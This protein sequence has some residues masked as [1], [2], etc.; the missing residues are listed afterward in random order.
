MKLFSI[1]LLASY[2][3]VDAFTADYG[4]SNRGSTQRTM[5]LK[6]ELN[7]PE[8]MKASAAM[9][10]NM[11]P[12]DIDMMLNQIENMPASETEQMRKMGMNP[13]V[14]KQ[15][16]R[17][18]KSNPEMAKQMSKM[19]ETMTPEEMMEKSREAQ[20][21]FSTMTPPPQQPE[22]IDVDVEE[23]NSD[24]PPPDAKVLDAMFEVGQL[25][26]NPQ[27]DGVTLQGFKS[28]PAINLLLEDNSN[29]ITTRRLNECWAI[30]S[31]GMSRV[32]RQ[33]FERVWL[34]V[35]KYVKGDI[36]SKA[37]ELG[38]SSSPAN[39]DVAQPATPGPQ[40]GASV[41]TEELEDRVKKM[42]DKDMDNMLDQMTNM[43]PEQEVRMKAMG[44]NPEMMRRTASMMQNNPLMKNAAK[45]M[46]K[47][48]S[49]DQ[50]K[51][52]SVQAQER[53]KNMSQEDMENMLKQMN[54][55]S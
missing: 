15:S 55:K 50:M 19:M 30:G 2:P 54:Q 22:V 43:T 17:M 49:G 41:S 35:Q 53:L 12:E 10:K 24:L 13:E 25:M 34:S 9:M 16:L 40:V 27:G 14:M 28:L 5:S 4:H 44:V 18:M 6:D 48:I 23:D 47:N 42:S 8:Y 36:M 33:G 29:K 26:S 21:R 1:L 45:S 52:A 11:K 3:A 37:R 32:D 46:M 38:S 51:A 20:E 31:L 39:Q 7:N